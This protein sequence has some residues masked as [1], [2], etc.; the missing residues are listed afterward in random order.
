V[1]DS[2]SVTW[3]IPTIVP[4]GVTV[5][6][7]GEHNDTGATCSGSIQ[8][9]LDGGI[10]DSVAGLASIALTVLTGAGLLGAAIPKGL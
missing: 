6:V 7:S 8:V 2:G 10:T 5:T 1:S 9:K 4:G 3:D